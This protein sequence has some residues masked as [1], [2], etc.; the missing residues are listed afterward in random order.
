MKA[1]FDIIVVGSGPA[2][3]SVAFPLLEAGYK[4]LMVDGGREAGLAPPAQEFL[5]W[6][7]GDPEQWTWMVGRDYYALRNADALSPKLRVPTQAYV[8]E[9]FTSANPMTAQDFTALGSLARGGLSRAWG[10]GVARYSAAEL[11]A[12]PFGETELVP[13]YAAVARR[14]GISGAAD[15][16]L[17]EYFGLDHWAE[18]PTPLDPL[19]RRL[20]ERYIRHGVAVNGAG[21]R[22]GRSRV[23]V[24]TKGRGGRQSCDLSG[25]CLWGCHRRAL[26]SATE[27]LELLK[28]IPHFQ[29]HPG[30]LVEAVGR[31]GDLTWV[32][33]GDG[34]LRRRYIARRLVLAAGALASTRLALNALAY[35][36]TVPLQSSPTAAFMLWLPALL[37]RQ[38]EPTF[39]L[40]QLAF[41]LDLPGGVSGYGSLF[42]PTGIPF[43]EF[44]GYL[45][46][47]RRYGIDLLRA[48]MSSCLVGNLFLPG[49]LTEATLS[50][51]A[52]GVLQVR[53][54]YRDEVAGLMRVAEQGLRRAFRKL[55]AV[56]LPGSFTLGRPGSDIHY[57]CSLPM[58]SSPARGETNACGELAGL[59]GVHVVDGASLS[60]LHE[61]PHTLTIMANADRIG[62]RLAEEKG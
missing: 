19:H 6:R 17:K 57:A 23:A 44:V 33:S 28:V 16:D 5:D 18:P 7:A 26:Y 25:N 39:G 45:P 32:V 52:E 41:S 21:V 55:G 38:R 43:A 24:L 50:V 48:L 49:H 62:R 46:F 9:G 34:I 40:G 47:R 11:A 22:L 54:H 27:D 58:R 20:L 59:P 1:D 53:G 4:V 12:F 3:V 56:M 13:S 60:A 10:C 29:H 37:G 31:E 2:G 14:M 8:F 35:T 36:R 15:D 30:F 51:D 42:N 61:K